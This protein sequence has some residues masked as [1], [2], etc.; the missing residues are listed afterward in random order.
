MARKTYKHQVVQREDVEWLE[1]AYIIGGS[2]KWQVS[3]R[4]L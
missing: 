2:I 3:V 4:F 1:F